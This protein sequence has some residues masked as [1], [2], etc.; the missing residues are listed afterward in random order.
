MTKTDFLL[1]AAILTMVIAGFMSAYKFGYRSAESKVYENC[2]LYNGHITD[3]GALLCEVISKR[4][5]V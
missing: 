3:R 1:C 2:T 4:G 5:T